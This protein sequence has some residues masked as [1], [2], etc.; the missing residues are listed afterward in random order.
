MPTGVYTRT[1]PPLAERF[2]ARV[3]RVSTADGCWPWIGK[4]DADGYGRTAFSE[5]GH[6]LAHRLAWSLSNDA[7]IPNGFDVLHTCDNPPCVRADEPG[8]YVIR[9]IA[10]PRWGHLWLGTHGDNMADR[11]A[12][13]RQPSIPRPLATLKGEQIGRSVLTEDQVREIRRLKRERG[14]P[15][16]ILAEMF[17]VKVPAIWAV[18]HRHTWKHVL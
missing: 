7:P 5:I 18:V 11:A 10:R 6:R 1:L 3:D 4:P 8:I 2:A 16:T 15:N 9:G 14:L 17:G 12:K 13:G